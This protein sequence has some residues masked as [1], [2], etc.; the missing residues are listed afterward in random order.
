MT[1][2]FETVRV[3]QT[4]TILA[5]CSIHGKNFQCLNLYFVILRKQMEPDRSPNLKS[6]RRAR[7]SESLEESASLVT[8]R[9]IPPNWAKGEKGLMKIEET[10]NHVHIVFF[11]IL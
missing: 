9:W 7:Y 8:K 2:V 1:S 10:C 6:K 4:S 11:C 5:S 3:F